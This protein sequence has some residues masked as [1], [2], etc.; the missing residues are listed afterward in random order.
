MFK[1]WELYFI[2]SSIKICPFCEQQCKA[3]CGWLYSM[4]E[5]S[6][7]CNTNHNHCQSVEPVNDTLPITV[8]GGN[9]RK[10]SGTL[11]MFKA[12]RPQFVFGW[13]SRKTRH[14]EA[15]VFRWCGLKSET[16]R[17]YSRCLADSVGCWS[18]LQ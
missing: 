5:S 11:L 13:S 6:L 10:L 9:K 7:H 18:H 2:M 3:Y 17:L 4:F 8:Y 12:R 16:D 15:W 1:N 14:C